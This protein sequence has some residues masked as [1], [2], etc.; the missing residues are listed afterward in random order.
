MEYTDI[1]A[2]LTL[3]TVYAWMYLYP[4]VGLIKDWPSTV[5]VTG[6]L[7]KKATNLFAVA[8]VAIMI[9]GGLMILFGVLPRYAALA[10]LAFNLGGAKIHYALA[11]VAKDTRLS[12]GASSDDKAA[13]ERLVGL[14]IVGHVTSA[15]KN[16]VLAAV[17][18]FFVLMGTGP[19]SVL[20]GPAIFP[21]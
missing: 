7:F 3:R 16:I 18:V 21:R 2:W 12:E 5:E 11:E 9:V 1:S 4:A 6:L 8:S 19:C 14:A 10:L 20:P 15:Q 17:A 13:H